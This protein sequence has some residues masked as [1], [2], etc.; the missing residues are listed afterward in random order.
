MA[1]RKATMMVTTPAVLRIWLRFSFM[2]V[3][4]RSWHSRH[5]WLECHYASI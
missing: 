5:E 1:P 4:L 3:I 2:A